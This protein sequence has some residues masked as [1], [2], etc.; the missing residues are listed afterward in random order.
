MEEK[1]SLYFIIVIFERN[2]SVSD[3]QFHQF[4]ARR[5]FQKAWLFLFIFQNVVIYKT[6]KVFEG[7]ALHRVDEIEP[8]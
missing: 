6:T 2:G 7:Y 5:K 1:R 4:G 8:R 3:A